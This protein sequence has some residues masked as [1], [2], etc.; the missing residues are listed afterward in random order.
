MFICQSYLSK[1]VKS[2]P[3]KRVSSYAAF[4]SHHIMCTCPEGTERMLLQTSVSPC[5]SITG[6]SPSRILWVSPAFFSCPFPSPLHVNEV[7]LS[8]RLCPHLPPLEPWG[9]SVHVNKCT[10]MCV[11]FW[12]GKERPSKAFPC[13]ICVHLHQ[14]QHEEECV[15]S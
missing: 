8:L 5:P 2:S 1:A 3:P 7:P 12:V 10:R 4:H 15:R 11:W 9:M 6:P 14:P 13:E